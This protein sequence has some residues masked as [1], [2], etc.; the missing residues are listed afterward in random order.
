MRALRQM[1]QTGQRWRRR[2]VGGAGQVA[3]FGFCS[4]G[5]LTGAKAHPVQAET[6]ICISFPLRATGD[7]VGDSEGRHACYSGRLVAPALWQTH[8]HVPEPPAPPLPD[9]PL[10]PTTRFPKRPGSKQTQELSR[11]PRPCLPWAGPSLG[12]GWPLPRGHRGTEPSLP[13][14]PATPILLRASRR[15]ALRPNCR[16][17]SQAGRTRSQHLLRSGRS[18]HCNSA[19]ELFHRLSSFPRAGPWSAIRASSRGRC[20]SCTPEPP[21]R[22]C[23]AP[24]PPPPPE[25]RLRRG[26]GGRATRSQLCPCACPV[27]TGAHLGLNQGLSGPPIR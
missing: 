14:P 7:P 22:G 21:G 23:G 10:V 13:A 8:G 20:P 18:L 17:G 6:A 1:A 25:G 26:P 24:H 5:A 3:V 12:Q 27:H 2:D 11:A 15:R 4:A 9:P 16:P 19:S